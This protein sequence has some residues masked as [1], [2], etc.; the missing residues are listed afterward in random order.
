MAWHD[1]RALYLEYLADQGFR[2]KVDEDDDI[3]FLFEGRHYY[4]MKTEEETF[5]HLLFPNFFSLDGEAEAAHA[6][7]AASAASRAT[8]I[9]KVYLNPALDNV[10]ASVELLV[11]GP[12]DIQDKFLR[13]L[14]ILGSATRQFTEAMNAQR[15]AAA[16]SPV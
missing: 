1:T 14:E 12:T 6:T 7:M 10:T 8:K 11:N 2:P 9:A 3:H 4:I 15:A 13:C 16:P 5:F